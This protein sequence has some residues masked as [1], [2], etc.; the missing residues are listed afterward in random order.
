MNKHVKM[1]ANSLLKGINPVVYFEDGSTQR[2]PVSFCDDGVT[3]T[4]FGRSKDAELV[5]KAEYTDESAVFYIDV[6]STLPLSDKPIIIPAE[7]DFAD[8]A[9]IFHHYC[10]LH[11]L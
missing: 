6:K 3:A 7:T 2:V 4:W 11:I 5:L 10:N 9:L 8:N 1:A